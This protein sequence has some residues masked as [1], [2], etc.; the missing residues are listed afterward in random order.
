MR[1]RLIPLI[2]FFYNPREAI[3]DLQA[4]TPY[5]AGAALAVAASFV[6][7]VLSGQLNSL[8]FPFHI[9]SDV[10][11]APRSEL[12]ALVIFVLAANVKLVLF[13]A[14]IFVPACLLAAS[15]IARRASF[16][17]LLRQEY[18]PLA[19]SMFYGWAAAQLASSV[20]AGLIFQAAAPIIDAIEPGLWLVPIPLFGFFAVLALH[21]V[22][23][24]SYGQALGVVVLAGLSL[25]ALPLLPGLPFIFSSPM[26]LIIL[27][28]VLRSF[29]ADVMSAQR[30]RENFQQNL[31]ASTLNPADASAHYNLG[32][33]Y[34]Q[35]G[36]YQD[37]AVCFRR[38][39]EI[40]PTE[41]DAHYQLGRIA[42]EEGRLAEAIAHF[43]STVRIASEHSQSEV[44]R[45][46]G[47]AYFE[48]GQYEDAR[49]AFERFLDKR[50]SDAEGRFRHGLT[51]DK[52]G[53][54]EEAAAEMRACIEAVR[55]APAFKYRAEKRWMS[56]AQSFLRSQT[57]R[58]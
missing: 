10:A 55:A 4:R 35:R 16:R 37:A 28:I 41:A 13:L 22:L 32:L 5:I 3:S 42:R 38:A 39:I 6:Y 2:K 17:V 20:V 30:A 58:G 15:L 9:T 8:L 29:F 25:L 57:A 45:E 36:Q 47:R 34:Q 53:R 31:K 19:A 24:L 21:A 7:Y 49:T 50:P 56:E 11:P 33:I 46:I 26:L 27:F 54:A 14:L 51:L 40:D 1:S 12:L 48:A 43:D 23:R 52:L 18:A 44:W